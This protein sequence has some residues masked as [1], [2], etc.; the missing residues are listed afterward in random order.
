MFDEAFDKDENEE[1][2]EALEDPLMKT[3][4][5]VIQFC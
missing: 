2:P 5:L 3:D 4:L 1:D